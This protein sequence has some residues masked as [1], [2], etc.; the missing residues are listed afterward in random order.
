[1]TNRWPTLWATALLATT[2]MPG[3]TSADPSQV[4][5]AWRTRDGWLTELRQ[6]TSGARVCVSGKDFRGAHPFGISLL[7]SGRIALVTVVDQLQPPATGDEMEFS[8]GGRKLGRFAAISQ[9]P[10]FATAEGESQRAWQLIS[11]LEP[12]TLSIA[13]A[14]REYQADLAGIVEARAQLQSCE[15]EAAR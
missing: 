5:Q 15:A 12:G 8:A 3:A 13:V 14:G 2:S 6:H 10:A 9:G 7:R 11:G 4:M 1:M